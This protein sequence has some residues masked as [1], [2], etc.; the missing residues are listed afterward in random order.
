V[1]TRERILDAAL[2][3]VDEVGVDRLR[4]RDLADRLSVTATAIYY[5]F[6]GRDQLVEGLVDHVCATI[7]ADV[8]VRETP[9]VRLTAVLVSLVDH[10]AAHPGASSWAITA[11]ARR[12]PMLA[13]HESMLELLAEEGLTL[14]QA[15][16]VKAAL[17]RYCIGHLVLEQAEPRG[18]VDALSVERDP[19]TIAAQPIIDETDRRRQFSAALDVMLTAL[20]DAA[21]R[22]A[23]AVDY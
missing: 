12:A 16:S 15:I 22:T 1:L 21:A 23:E 8:P 18:D 20:V 9:R 6:D 19:L 10:A 7:L 13:L 2:E 4:M 11:F 3:I 17:L 5:Y 14:A